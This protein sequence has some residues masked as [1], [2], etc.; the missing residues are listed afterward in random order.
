MGSSRESENMVMNLRILESI[1][2]RWIKVKYALYMYESESMSTFNKRVIQRS[3]GITK[4]KL[5]ESAIEENGKDVTKLIRKMKVE[6]LILTEIRSLKFLNE[7]A[8]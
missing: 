7:N 1:Q 4:V 3:S 5:M 6:E 8:Q 2:L